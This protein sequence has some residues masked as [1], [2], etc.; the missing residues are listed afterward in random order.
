MTTIGISL[1]N[2]LADTDRHWLATHELHFGTAPQTGA[3][4]C[5]AILRDLEM[6]ERWTDSLGPDWW[7]QIPPSA[8]A[9]GTVWTLLDAGHTIEVLTQRSHR[10]RTVR[11]ATQDWIEDHWPAGHAVPRAHFVERSYAVV[12]CGV[13]VVGTWAE[14]QPLAEA[15]A[16][17]VPFRLVDIDKDARRTI[18]LPWQQPRSSWR[19]FR[20]E[21][22][23][24]AEWTPA[25]RHDA[26]TEAYGEGDP[27]ARAPRMAQ[28][29]TRTIV[30]R[31]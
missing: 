14:Y 9:I 24:M 21:L 27:A 5:S 17:V 13:Y 20:L 4:G 11:Q 12:D 10:D 3:F 2:V 6:V 8:C 26:L 31:R 28:R 22:L 29:A 15:R 19:E 25:E 23:E 16:L 1:D 18:K 7:R 30:N